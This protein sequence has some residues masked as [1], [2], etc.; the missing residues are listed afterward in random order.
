MASPLLKSTSYAM[1]A[2]SGLVVLLGS[3]LNHRGHKYSYS[4]RKDSQCGHYVVDLY[5]EDSDLCCDPY[6]HG[7]DLVCQAAFDKTTR[8]LSSSWAFL[9]PL[10]PA[11]ITT[12]VDLF[13]IVITPTSS[14]EV[15]GQNSTQPPSL[16]HRIRLS[17]PSLHLQRFV[18]Y[19]LIIVIR[20]VSEKRTVQ[21]SP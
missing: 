11:I 8:Q 17:L 16:L 13:L 15:P 5:Q 21:L 4:S 2:V 9:L 18:T 3:L 10:L 7:N 19:F 1:L 20:V 12:L 14:A 6:H